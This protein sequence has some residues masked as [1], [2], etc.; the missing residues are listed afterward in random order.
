MFL[1]I[2]DAIDCYSPPDFI[3]HLLIYAGTKLKRLKHITCVSFSGL[4]TVVI[5]H[6][7]CYWYSYCVSPEF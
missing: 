3:K 4:Y 6:A 1:Y 2:I 7:A 5:T